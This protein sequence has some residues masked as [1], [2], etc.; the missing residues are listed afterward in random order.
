MSLYDVA[1]MKVGEKKQ[2]TDD[3]SDMVKALMTKR[4]RTTMVGAIDSIEK[5]LGFL[6]LET[7][8]RELTKE[9]EEMKELFLD[10]RKEIL[11]K[12]N[13]QIRQLDDDLSKFSITRKV[14]HITLPVKG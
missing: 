9:E 4:I 14:Y 7:Q 3:C 11:D 8:D 2:T 10:L 1:K 6:F 5:I 12:G 13:N